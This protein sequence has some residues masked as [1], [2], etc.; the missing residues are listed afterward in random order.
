MHIE[1]VELKYKNVLFVSIPAWLASKV[2]SVLL[3]RPRFAGAGR[4]SHRQD[5]E[6]APYVL[7][8]HDSICNPAK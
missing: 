4:S 1:N 3:P 2:L 8:T 5:Y 6:K 7:S